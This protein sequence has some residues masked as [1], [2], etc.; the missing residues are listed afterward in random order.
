MESPMIKMLLFVALAFICNV[1]SQGFWKQTNG[2]GGGIVFSLVQNSIGHIFAATD[3]GVFRSANNGDIWTRLINDLPPKRIRSIAANNDGQIFA[4]IWPNGLF[5]STDDGDSWVHLTNGLTDSLIYNITANSNGDLYLAQNHEI[6]RSTDNGNNWV[7]VFSQLYTLNFYCNPKGDVFAG[8][9]FFASSDSYGLLYRSTDNGVNWSQLPCGFDDPLVPVAC[10]Q[11]SLIFVCSID[12]EFYYSTISRSVNNGVNFLPVNFYLDGIIS[13]IIIN[14]SGHVFVGSYSGIFRSPDNG[15][16][17]LKI[18][19]GLTD[20]VIYSLLIDNN[21]YIF[22]GSEK[23]LV[24]RSVKSTTGIKDNVAFAKSFALNQNYPNPFNPSTVISYTLPKSSNVKLIVYNA[25]GQ[26]VKLLENSFKQPGNYS[27][28]FN[29]SS[30]PSA[31]Y[32]YKL[33]AGPFSQIKKM[34]LLK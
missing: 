16:N 25:L 3:S 24:F 34:I 17:W 19:S 14:P 13:S 7:Q 26:T 22:A 12:R 10:S 31:I 33:E 6:Y 30:I 5:R 27:V 2:P 9:D 23:G 32:F 21:G 29:A 1:Y 28:S 8:G 4:V 20:S 15:D 18:N 11:D